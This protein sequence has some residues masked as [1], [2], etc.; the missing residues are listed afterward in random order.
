MPR[1]WVLALPV[2]VACASLSHSGAYVA[3]RNRERLSALAPGMSRD[4]VVATMGA[5][6]Y[7]IRE[8]GGLRPF[9]VENPHH[10]ARIVLRDG[11][12][13]E[14]L[15]YYTDLA[16]ADG[17]ASIDE[18]TPVVLRGER[19]LATGWDWVQAEAD[20]RALEELERDE[21]AREIRAAR[22][23]EQRAVGLDP[24]EREYREAVGQ[25]TYLIRAIY[26]YGQSGF[27]F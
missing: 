3:D 8:G 25:G 13:A 15:Y 18:L 20:P 5:R 9:A 10:E 2:L 21:T 7:R 11:S 23:S 17:F 6:G 16:V 22:L 27:G 4:A 1:A 12:E 26:G 14:L 24:A 19:L